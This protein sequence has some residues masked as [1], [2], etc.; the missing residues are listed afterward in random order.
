[1]N[2][3]TKIEARGTERKDGAVPDYVADASPVL[4]GSSRDERLG[5]I[6]ADDVCASVCEQASV[7]SLPAAQIE[8]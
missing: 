8:A 1:M 2:A 6:E 4:S 5:D 3:V 7:V